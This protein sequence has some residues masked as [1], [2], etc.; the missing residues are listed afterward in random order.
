MPGLTIGLQKALF[1]CANDA[2]KSLTHSS[3]PSSE[4]QVS[5]KYFKMITQL[6]GVNHGNKNNK[7]HCLQG[8]EMQLLPVV[9]V[10]TGS[11]RSSEEQ[12]AFPHST[13]KEPCCMKEFK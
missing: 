11:W 8:C 10:E 2:R 1:G 5:T 7:W 6:F 13:L 3:P 4:G 12:S 9:V